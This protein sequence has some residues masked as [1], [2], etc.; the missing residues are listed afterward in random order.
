M[1]DRKIELKEGERLDDLQVGGCYLIQ[2]KGTFCLSTDAV[3]LADF[4]RPRRRDRA[5]DMGCG[6]GA[7][8]ILMAA[9]VPELEVDAVELQPEMAD[10]ARRSVIYDG[11]SGRVRVHEG[12]M[13][14][15]WRALGRDCAS[16]VVCNPPY[17][18]K[19]RT[20]PSL[21]EPER[22]ARHEDDLTPQEVAASADR[23][24]RFGGRFCVVYPAQRAFEMMQAMHSCG[25]APKRLRSVHAQADKAPKLVLIEAVK[26][27]GNGLHWLPPL[28]L[29]SAPGTPTP[30]YMRIYSRA[31]Q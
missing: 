19:G 17:G 16:L 2:R 15:A 3:L 26:G 7:I 11:L 5:V 14:Q 28:I 13:R 9:H 21:N 10:M 12:D 8:A 30:E 27:G 18:G 29:Y 23:L 4:A 24:L 31:S 6:N 1:E 25:L 20:L 22:I